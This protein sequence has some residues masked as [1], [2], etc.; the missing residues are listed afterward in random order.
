MGGSGFA[1]QAKTSDGRPAW[2]ALDGS[3]GT[4]YASAEY[5][6]SVQWFTFYN[7]SPL[8]VTK[9]V[10]N[11]AVEG[12]YYSKGITVQGSNNNSAWTDIVKW[13][14]SSYTA[15]FTIDM[16]SNTNAYKYYRLY[17]TSRNYYS[18][19]YTNWRLV[20]LTITATQQT[21]V[22][23][24]EDDYDYSVEGNNKILPVSKQ[25][26][27]F[28]KYKYQNFV[29][30]NI[31]SNGIMG[32]NSFTCT[33]S[34]LYNSEYACLA[35]DGSNT[36]QWTNNGN[37]GSITFYNPNPLSITKLTVMNGCTSG[38]VRPISSGELLGSNDGT[39]FTSI[40]TFTNSVTGLKA[41]WNIDLSSN[42]NFYK[43]HRLSVKGDGSYARITELGITAQERIILNGTITDYDF[44]EIQTKYYMI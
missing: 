34:N 35:F 33:Q 11:Q 26:K 31:T 7:P 23:S 20:E 13:T 27:K 38:Y 5:D 21:I 41:T 16:S 8:K 17:C 28:Y 6:S 2:Y 22:E 37:T 24:T 10:V 40:K 39:N 14:G 19:H 44:Y 15:T 36:T 1:V 30:P 3:T 29:R 18:S 43:Y 25:V 12:Y 32:G 9:I 42:K 4:H